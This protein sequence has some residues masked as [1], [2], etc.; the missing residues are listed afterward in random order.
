MSNKWDATAMPEPSPR[1]SVL[2]L[3]TLGV[4]TATRFLGGL[5]ADQ[6]IDPNAALSEFIQNQL[7]LFT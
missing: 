3:Q 4:R 5:A 6:V 1:A 7:Q 2:K